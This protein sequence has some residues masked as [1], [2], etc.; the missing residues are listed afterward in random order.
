MSGGEFWLMYRLAERVDQV[1]V[2]RQYL[3]NQF[4]YGSFFSEWAAGALAYEM[5]G[6]KHPFE[7]RTFE[8]RSYDVKYL[9]QLDGCVCLF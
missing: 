5:F 4:M 3:V 8:K 9:P 2:G 7:D 6:Q 1:I